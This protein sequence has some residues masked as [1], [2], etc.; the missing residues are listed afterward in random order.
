MHA[1]THTL[2]QHTLNIV[3]EQVKCKSFKNNTS[4]FVIENDLIVIFY[5]VFAKYFKDCLHNL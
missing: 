1:H 5:S 3:F 4:D 2:T